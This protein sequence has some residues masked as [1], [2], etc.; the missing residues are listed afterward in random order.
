MSSLGK[1]R[2]ERE[3][4][5]KRGGLTI[6]TLIDPAAQAAAEAAVAEQIAPTDPVWGSTVLIQ[7]STGLIVA[8][9][10]S[11][12]DMGDGPGET[13]YNI[14]AS[15]QMGGLEGFQAGSTFKPFTL[16]AALDM[17]MTPDREYNAPGKIDTKG[18][19]FRDCQGSFTFNQDKSPQNQGQG[20]FG[21]I[22][23]V[24]A[25]EKSVNTYFMQLI[26]DVGIC[27]SIDMAS[28]AGVKLASGQELRS[29]QRFPSF[30]LGV[31][32]EIG[33]PPAVVPFHGVEDAVDDALGQFQP[34][35]EGAVEEHGLEG[36]C[37][38]RLATHGPEGRGEAGH[39]VSRYGS[40]VSGHRVLSPLAGNSSE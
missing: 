14:N 38:R 37:R 13:Y 16:A 36:R 21:K 7:P 12:P 31:A 20:G 28:K 39:A 33:P 18:W 10:Q 35:G 29:M 15:T 23:M 30:V 9:A 17:G 22:D 24:E 34:A 32:D 11:R 8:M 27:A 4:L 25:T 5:L 3:N 1:T 19:T 2:E 6:H 26:R 40:A